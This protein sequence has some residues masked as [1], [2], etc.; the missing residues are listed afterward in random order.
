MSTT[1]QALGIQ[2]AIHSVTHALI[3]SFTYFLEKQPQ[4]SFLAASYSKLRPREDAAVPVLRPDPSEMLAYSKQR[5]GLLSNTLQCMGQ[6]PTK[7]DPG[8]NAHSA[9]AEKPLCP[10]IQWIH[11]PAT[12]NHNLLSAHL[13]GTTLG[14]GSQTLKHEGHWN[15]SP[16]GRSEKPRR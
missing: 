3:R 5:T 4:A 9:K 6:S 8:P 12:E 10:C 2:E 1:L 15:P 7:N 11:Y 14:T 13:T 16:S